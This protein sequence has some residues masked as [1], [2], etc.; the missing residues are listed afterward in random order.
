MKPTFYS[1]FRTSI[2]MMVTLL[3]VSVFNPVNGQT[4]ACSGTIVGTNPGTI[5]SWTGG[6]Q[7]GNGTPGSIEVCVV[8]NDLVPAGMGC[9]SNYIVVSQDQ[10]VNNGIVW[11]SGTLSNGT[12]YTVPNTTG[13]AWL[14]MSPCYT[15]SITLSWNT[16]D[17]S[18]NDACVETCSD[19]IQ[20]QD[21]TGID[22]GG[23]FCPPCDCFNGVQ[24]PGETG[25]DCGGPCAP[26]GTCFDGIQ[27]GAETG[28]DCGGP[29]CLPCST[30]STLF[31][32]T[33]CCSN[34]PQASVYPTN[35]DQIGTSAYDL[36]S[37]IIETTSQASG[38]CLPSPAPTGCGAPTGTGS[39]THMTLEDG[40]TYL[41][42]SWAQGAND[43]IG[44]GNSTTWSALYQGTSCAALNFVDCQQ[45]VD[46]SASGYY[47]YQAQWTGLNPNQDVWIYTWNDNNKGFNLDLQYIGAQTTASNTDTDG[48]LCNDQS[49]AIGSACNLG[50]V[51][52]NFTTPAAG[53]VACSGGNW[54]SNENTTFYSFVA[55]AT[56]GSLEVQNIECNNG[57]SGN[58][59][60]AVWTNC[61][62]IGTYGADFLG[63]AVGTSTISL[64]PLVPGQTYYI[65][66][67]GFAGDNCAWSFGG[68]GILL[69][70]EL[71]SFTAFHN[72]QEVELYWTTI[73]EENNDYFTVQR[74]LD[75][76]N[77]EDIGLVMGAGT[78]QEMQDYA[79]IDHNPYDGTSYYRIRQTDYDGVYSY[80]EVLAVRNG[81]E[82]LTIVKTVNLMGQEIGPEYSGV[83]IDIFSD[84]ST[85][86]R[87]KL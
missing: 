81:K 68:T 79:F 64:S 12:C 43:A 75:G 33:T 13:Y 11:S 16:V 83:V 38:G 84:G 86:K 4:N 58:A 1:F 32:S 67:D 34:T 3:F 78:T 55:D 15:G 41:Q 66:A 42:S 74:T 44:S 56:T 17:G 62:S 14:A 8:S 77:F 46:F 73:S 72:T 71:G 35:C 24:D 19:G 49:T 40:V 45:I 28:V 27:N 26:C 59:Q 37:P 30:N 53:G 29:T 2:V 47:I 51:G 65:V 10:G 20:N 80:S 36:N 85:S 82:G 60:F 25:I 39:W 23:T 54:G 21:E 61:T 48:N 6:I 76:R 31:S 9:N 69:P 63:C 57:V 50:A 70:I 5:P 52:A 18:G 22:C 87:I 7:I